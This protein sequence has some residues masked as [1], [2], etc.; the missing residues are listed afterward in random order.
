MTNA[1]IAYFVGALV[2]ATIAL[3]LH[4]RPFGYPR[5]L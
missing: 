2:G 3:G 4:V 5:R 1:Q